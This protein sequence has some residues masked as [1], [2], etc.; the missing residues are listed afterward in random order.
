MQIIN[1]LGKLKIAI[2]ACCMIATIVQKCFNIKIT[3]KLWDAFMYIFDEI[4]HDFIFGKWPWDENGNW[5]YWILF[6]KIYFLKAFSEY[7]K[8]GGLLSTVL[9]YLKNITY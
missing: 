1:A 3:G 4:V 6:K 5:E 2:T 8:D 7:R 9:M